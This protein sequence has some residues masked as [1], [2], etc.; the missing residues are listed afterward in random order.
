MWRLCKV[1]TVVVLIVV[2]AWAANRYAAILLL[3]AT[4]GAP[5]IEQLYPKPS[6]LPARVDGT[7][8][9]L[10]SRLEGVLSEKCPN[11]LANL[12]PGLSRDEIARLE[13]E[14]GIKLSKELKELYAWH[15][16]CKRS[17]DVFVPDH[18]FQSFENVIAHRQMLAGAIGKMTDAQRDTWQVYVAFRNP[19]LPI[20]TDAAGDG[21]F[22]DPT[23][24]YKNGA[25]FYCF[26]E[27]GTY[28]FLT[29]FENL[30]AYFLECYESGIYK[31]E[32][33]G[34][35]LSED[36]EKAATVVNHYAQIVPMR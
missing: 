8:S 32:T 18:T 1:L 24:T 11:V 26:Q 14:S 4:V 16:G 15:K 6:R 10:L 29:S 20:F 13:R 31:A 36:F 30:L 34:T 3:R 21:Y 33:K 28:N 25:L 23:K 22:L 19:W 17:T 9:E 5:T 7:T 35:G 12:N 2:A 27:Q